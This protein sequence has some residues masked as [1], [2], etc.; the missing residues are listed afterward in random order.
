MREMSSGKGS[1][2]QNKWRT[3]KCIQFG[4]KG[5]IG[6]GRGVSYPVLAA[7]DPVCTDL[8]PLGLERELRTRTC[9]VREYVSEQ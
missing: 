6:G 2:R 8:A 3:C 5:P 9:T 1:C 4:G 7:H